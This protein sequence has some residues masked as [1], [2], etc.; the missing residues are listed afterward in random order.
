M[1][2]PSPATP[3]M[4][5]FSAMA[6]AFEWVN[7]G[8]RAAT[9]G[10]RSTKLAAVPFQSKAWLLKPVAAPCP[11]PTWKAPATPKASEHQSLEG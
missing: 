7:A 8:F 5:P 11:C 2:L 3:M 9:K 10:W 1:F 4:L 6:T